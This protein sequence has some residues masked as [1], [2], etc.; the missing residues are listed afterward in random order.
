MGSDEYILSA[1]IWVPD[2][3]KH[4]YQPYNVDNGLVLCGWRHPTIRPQI[5]ALYYPNWMNEHDLPIE[6]QP[7]VQTLRKEVQGFITNTN[8]FVDR[9]E[10]RE[11]AIAANQVLDMKI[12]GSELFSE[13]LY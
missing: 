8:R 13:D 3:I 12:L 9:I 11:I 4:R 1:A 6:E 10:G 7:R 5:V 2:G